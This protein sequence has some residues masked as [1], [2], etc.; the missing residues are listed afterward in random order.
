[1]NGRHRIGYTDMTKKKLV[2]LRSIQFIKTF[3]DMNIDKAYDTT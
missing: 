2:T 1:M 3:N